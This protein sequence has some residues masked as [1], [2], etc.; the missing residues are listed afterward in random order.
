MAMKKVRAQSP[1][2]TSEDQDT[3]GFPRY[4]ESNRAT[5][6]AFGGGGMD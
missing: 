4:Q 6:T 5:V 1:D 3:L 2:L